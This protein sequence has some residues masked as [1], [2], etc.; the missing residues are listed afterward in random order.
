MKIA[1]KLGLGLLAQFP[2]VTV[3]G[4]CLVGAVSLAFAQAGARLTPDVAFATVRQELEKINQASRTLIGLYER[5]NDR[6]AAKDLAPKIDRA[7]AAEETAEAALANAMR[8]LD[9]KNEQHKTLLSTAFDDIE[10]TDRDER[11]AW[12]A[13]V[14]RQ[15]AAEVA[16]EAAA[17]KAENSVINAER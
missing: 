11:T 1:R 3:A 14:D 13:A 12:L 17:E 16:A 10:T 6:Q 7:I 5:A 15:L 2:A 4:A 9:L 8:F